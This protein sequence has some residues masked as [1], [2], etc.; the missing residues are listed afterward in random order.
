MDL[1]IALWND[2][3]AHVYESGTWKAAL[4]TYVPGDFF[5]VAVEGGV[6]KYYINGSLGYTSQVAPTYPLLVDTSLGGADSTINN[7]V[8]YRIR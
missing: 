8:I 5:R 3:T 1:S 6:V 4:G 7:A 2:G